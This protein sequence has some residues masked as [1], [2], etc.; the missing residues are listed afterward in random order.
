M[1]MFLEV[2][3]LYLGCVV[4][5]EDTG[6]VLSNENIQVFIAIIKFFQMNIFEVFTAI[7][8]WKKYNIFIL[9]IN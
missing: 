1:A 3:T 2:I 5:H 6:K 4:R 9:K 7:I 8:S